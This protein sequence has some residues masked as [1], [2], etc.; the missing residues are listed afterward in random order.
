MRH[1]L[2]LAVLALALAGCT[3]PREEG[4]LVGQRAP[5]I[6]VATTDGA[7]W[8]LADHRGQVVL[9]DLM[10]VNCPPCRREMPLLVAFARAHAGDASLALLSVDMA[11]AFPALGAKDEGEVQA[12]RAAYNA[13]WPFASDAR[14]EVGRAYELLILPTKLVIDREGIIRAKVATEIQS[15]QQL[16]DLVAR[17]GA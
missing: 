9:V 15:V 4:P 5:P 8:S 16:E 1:A 3:T 12:F 7:T 11:S 13:T 14:G 6:S 17:A 2:A 10:G